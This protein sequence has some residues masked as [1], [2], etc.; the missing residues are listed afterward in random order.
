MI[1]A[2]RASPGVGGVVAGAMI[3]GREERDGTRHRRNRA[4]MGSI[5][6][7]IQGTQ[8][9][10]QQ[11]KCGVYGVVVSFL[12]EGRRRNYPDT[13]YRQVALQFID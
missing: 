10:Q 9:Q 5:T 13:F 1:P 6:E 8:E 4:M 2:P 12:L 7:E 3:K 11:Q